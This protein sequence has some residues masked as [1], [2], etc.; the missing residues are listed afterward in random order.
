MATLDGWP[1]ILSARVAAGLSAIL[2]GAAAGPAVAQ[3]VRVS[4]SLAVTLSHSDNPLF[5][6]DDRAR[7]DTQLLI[8]PR[9]EVRRTGPRLRLTAEAGVDAVRHTSRDLSDA[10][11]PSFSGALNAELIDNWFFLDSSARVSSVEVD[12]LGPRTEVGVERNSRRVVTGTFSPYIDYRLGSNF[13][14]R[15]RSE[16]TATRTGTA[17]D[18]SSAEPAR[19]QLSVRNSLVI[20][21]LPRPLGATIEASS[22]NVRYTN[23]TGPLLRDDALRATVGYAL[24]GDTTVSVVMGR[25]RSRF[26]ADQETTDPIRGI[27]LAWRPNE[28]TRLDANVERRFFGNGYSVEASHR[29]P[30]LTSSVSVR[31]EPITNPFTLQFG[32]AG[33]SLGSFLDSILTTRYPDPAERNRIVSDIL[34]SRGLPASLTSPIGIVSQ[35]AQ[36]Q[37]GGTLTFVLLGARNTFTASLYGVTQRQLRRADDPLSSGQVADSD[38]RQIGGTLG[39]NRR[40]SPQWALDLQAEW[41][42]VEALAARAGDETTQR[43]FRSAITYAISPRTDANAGLSWRSFDST[44]STPSATRE[45]SAFAGLLHRF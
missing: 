10:V 28:R 44:L 40:L 12:P 30:W 4:P 1:V 23:D 39:F 14:V 43:R 21:R 26:A 9:L 38:T 5:V 24:S 16:T 45:L 11:R 27:R 7:G 15:G 2:A 33:G 8:S 22:D 41:S 3:S 18:D 37:N 6:G 19:T 34:A 20:E 35:Y 32:G 29:M 25:E 42:K 36:L 31:R 13:A 17:D